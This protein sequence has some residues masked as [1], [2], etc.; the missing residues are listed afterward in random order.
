METPFTIKLGFKKL[1]DFM[2]ETIEAN[3]NPMITSITIGLLSSLK[4]R[5]EL[6][7]GVDPA[8][9]DEYKEEIDTL[10]CLLFPHAL[11]GNEIK[12]A[13]PPVSHEILYASRRFST[14]FGDIT[15]L[16]P[17][18]FENFDEDHMYITMCT[19]ILGMYYGINQNI[20]RP[21][22]YDVLAANGIMRHYKS[23]YNADFIEMI[24]YGEAPKITPELLKELRENFDDITL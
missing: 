11:T 13:T 2:D 3:E 19:F 23:V 6:S 24:P 1:F 4:Y 14:I 7:A 8:A 18:E 10:L 5:S 9:I 20:M 21:P 12:I 16:E 17:K 22:V 15:E